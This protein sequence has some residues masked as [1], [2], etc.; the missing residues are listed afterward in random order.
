MKV[1]NSL[2]YIFVSQTRLKLIGT[3]FFS[4]RDIYYVRQLVRLVGEEINSVRRELEN[5]KKAGVLESEWRGN[6][7]YYSANKNSPLFLDLLVIA[8][9]INGLG[10]ALIENKD[11]VGPVKLLVYSYNFLS[12]NPDRKGDI[13]LIIVGDISFR[14]VEVLIKAEEERRGYEINYMVMDKNE[15]L[16]RKQKRDQFIVDFFLNYPIVII[17]SPQ[18]VA[19]I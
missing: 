5:M 15:L 16:L 12:G 10:S 4:P 1:T 7:L 17:G 13:D 11:K 6:R 14:E 9:K 19:N 2:K 18:E 3:L 8:N